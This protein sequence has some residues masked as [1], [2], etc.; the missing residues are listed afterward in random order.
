MDMK[1]AENFRINL[2]VA[3]ESRDMTQQ[4]V[5]QLG[6]MSLAYVNRVLRGHTNPSLDQCERLA[7]AVS[8]PLIALLTSPEQFADSVLIQS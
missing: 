6:Q 3:L 7:R 1:A 4:Q 2:R 8:F 5:A